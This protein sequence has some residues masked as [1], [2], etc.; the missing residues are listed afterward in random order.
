MHSQSHKP[1]ALNSTF[2]KISSQNLL[3]KL[4]N[5]QVLV[6]K[7]RLEIKEPFSKGLKSERVL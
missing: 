4:F 1:D 3:K 6:V 5:S 7:T 2:D